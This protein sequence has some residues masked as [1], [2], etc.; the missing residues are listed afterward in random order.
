MDI[1]ELI[2][3]AEHAVI[4]EQDIIDLNVRL[5]LFNNKVDM[6]LDLS[7]VYNI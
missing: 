7:I 4:S 3:L 2:S 6:P 5:E 1:A